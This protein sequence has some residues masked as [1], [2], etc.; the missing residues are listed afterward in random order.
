MLWCW[1]FE[2]IFGQK[3]TNDFSK[4][5]KAPFSWLD[6]PKLETLWSILNRW[7]NDDFIPDFIDKNSYIKKVL[8]AHV[9]KSL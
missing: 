8:V 3:I 1:Y 7:E 6:Y 5:P 4:I 9:T 2:N